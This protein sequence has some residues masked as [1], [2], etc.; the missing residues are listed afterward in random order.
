[1]IDWNA[2]DPSRIAHVFS[3]TPTDGGDDGITLGTGQAIVIGGTGTD[4]I[5]GGTSTAVILG[6]SGRIDEVAGGL[7]FGSLPLALGTVTTIADGGA[8]DLIT[9]GSGSNVVLG[10]AGA[11]TITLG[12]GTNVVLGDEGTIAW[13]ADGAIASIA[14]FASGQ[15]GDDQIT[16]GT[17]N[18]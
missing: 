3:T 16:I 11:D 2:L 14:T 5:G 6:D 12:T 10:G 9:T 13:A 7:Q 4:T 1:E 15:G 8:S 17:G 18:A